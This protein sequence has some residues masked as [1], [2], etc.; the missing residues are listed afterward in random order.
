MTSRYDASSPTGKS[1]RIGVLA[2]PA[3]LAERNRIGA[4]SYPRAIWADRDRP[5]RATGGNPQLK[6]R[7]L[8][9]GDGRA[10]APHS[11]H[12]DDRVEENGASAAPHNLK[13]NSQQVT[14]LVRLR[15][16]NSKR[17]EITTRAIDEVL[18]ET[19]YSTLPFLKPSLKW[20]SSPSPIT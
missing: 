5:G 19:V 6:K 8:F 3:V 12:L 4:S 11:T 2:V 7:R 20:E 18:G 17:E 1:L 15:C 13:H 16:P 10:P 9:W 14:C